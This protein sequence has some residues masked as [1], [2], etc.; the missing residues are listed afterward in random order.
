MAKKVIPI[1][2]LFLF[3]LVLSNNC[4]AQN[5]ENDRI[6][7]YGDD[8]YSVNFTSSQVYTAGSTLRITVYGNTLS[9]HDIAY[10]LKDSEGKMVYRWQHAPDIRKGTYNQDT[11]EITIPNMWGRPTGEWEIEIYFA[12]SIYDHLHI[13]FQVQ[14]GNFWDNLNA[15]IYIYKGFRIFNY[16]VSNIKM[17]LP[18]I[19]MLISPLI[20]FL[21]IFFT[22]KYVKFAYKEGKSIISL[23]SK[24]I[25][26]AWRAK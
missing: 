18:S 16:E 8:T 13:H 11:F 4:K 21:I 17:Q 10:E 6:Y 14:K 2:I 24:R 5:I 9:E 3:L 12:H 26:E 25:K 22:I 15:P 23:S 7:L 20:L 1:A 19:F